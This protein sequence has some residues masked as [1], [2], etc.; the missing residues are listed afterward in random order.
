ML[1]LIS[2]ICDAGPETLREAAVQLHQSLSR[3]N[4]FRV[5]ERGKP[6]KLPPALDL[7]L[8]NNLIQSDLN[9]KEKMNTD[10][11]IPNIARG[12]LEAEDDEKVK[13]NM[14]IYRTNYEDV[15]KIIKESLRSGRLTKK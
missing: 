14:E 11:V 2:S 9:L 12:I 6:K 8:R 5:D 10:E 15:D 13:E 7:E 3:S 1:I 4:S